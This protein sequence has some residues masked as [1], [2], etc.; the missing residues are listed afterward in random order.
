[1]KITKD[2]IF[3]KSLI[4]GTLSGVLSALLLTVIFAFII[5]SGNV[6]LKTS[7]FIASMILVISSFIGGFLASKIRSE[8]GLIT[9]A[10][11]GFCF[12]VIIVALSLIILKSAVTSSLVIKFAIL[13]FSAAIGGLVGVNSLGKFKKI[14]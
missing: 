10:L 1:M 12:Y 3:I 11:T 5:S 13:T 14:I 2:N 6:S 8:K 7:G 9:G 4:L